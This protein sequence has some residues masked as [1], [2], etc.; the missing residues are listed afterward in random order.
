MRYFRG[1]NTDQADFFPVF[2]YD[3]VTV[4]DIFYLT[5]LLRMH[6]H[7]DLCNCD[8]DQNNCDDDQKF[9]QGESGCSFHVMMAP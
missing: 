4:D 7:R 3:G 9:N 8:Q 1:I 5:P 2:Q 6:C